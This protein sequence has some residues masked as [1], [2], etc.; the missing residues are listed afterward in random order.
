MSV[1]VEDATDIVVDGPGLLAAPLGVGAAV[2]AAVAAAGLDGDNL[3]P[4][5]APTPGGERFYFSFGHPIDAAAATARAPAGGGGDGGGDAADA[6]FATV[7]AAVPSLYFREDVLCRVPHCRACHE[8]GS[9]QLDAVGV[10]G[11]APRRRRSSCH[12]GAPHLRGGARLR[13]CAP[14]PH[15]AP[16]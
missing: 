7:K 14:H 11:E 2:R 8:R 10:A 4:L 5:V 1:G 12:V 6:L 13:F 3:M 15:H 16:F 9:I